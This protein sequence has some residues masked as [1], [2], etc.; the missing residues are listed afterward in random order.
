MTPA[1]LDFSLVSIL[2]TSGK[3]IVGT[4]F[5]NKA[6]DSHRL[7][8]AGQDVFCNKVLEGS[9]RFDDRADQSLEQVLVVF[10]QQLLGVFW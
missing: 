10:C 9:I 5:H 6:V 7:G 8:N 3:V 1:P 4:S 2:H